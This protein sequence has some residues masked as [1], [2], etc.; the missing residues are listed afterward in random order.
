M[1]REPGTEGEHQGRGPVLVG[2]PTREEL[3]R[4]VADLLGVV[5]VLAVGGDR[6]EHGQDHGRNG[7]GT[8]GHGGVGGADEDRLGLLRLIIEEVAEPLGEEHARPVRARGAQPVVAGDGIGAHGLDPVSTQERSHVGQQ[9]RH[10][11]CRRAARPSSSTARR[12]RP[13]PRPARGARAGRTWSAPCTV[14]V[15]YRSSRSSSANHSSHPSTVA[16]R[17]LAQAGCI[18]SSTSAATRSLSF[19]A[20][21]WRNASFAVPLLLAPGRGSGVQLRDEVGLASLQLT[22]QQLAEQPVVAV[23]VR[24]TVERE[25]EEAP[26][27]ELLQPVR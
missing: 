8:D 23:V 21:A 24:A 1:D 16:A 7:V 15:G 14:R 17:P 5:P 2:G 22:A 19:A 3:Q 18:R 27:L 10:A 6:A 26:T 4:A 25:D 11:S 12:R 13:T 9:A 20:W